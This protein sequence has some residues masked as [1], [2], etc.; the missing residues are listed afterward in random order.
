MLA[1]H[2]T[3]IITY[4]RMYVDWTDGIHTAIL[5]TEIE[6]RTKNKGDWVTLTRTE[7][8]EITG[9]TYCQQQT[10]RSTLIRLGFTLE[11]KK[12]IPPVLQFQLTES[13]WM[14]TK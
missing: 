4:H 8:W 1:D 12:G 2:I 9:L 5:L 3:G 14:N 7:L 10:A 11:R 13:F 6:R